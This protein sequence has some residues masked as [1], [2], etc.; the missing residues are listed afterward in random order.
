VKNE[1]KGRSLAHE[2]C[3]VLTLGAGHWIDKSK[4]RKA[5]SDWHDPNDPNNLMYPHDTYKKGEK[6]IES[7]KKLTDDQIKEIQRGA[8]RLGKT[9]V[10]KR[11]INERGIPVIHQMVSL[12]TVHGGFVD[13]MGDVGPAY[14]DLGAGFLYAETPSAELQMSLLLEGMFPEVVDGFVI[15]SVYFDTDNDATTGDAFY[16]AVGVDK[17][18]DVEVGVH[19]LID[20]LPWDFRPGMSFPA[21]LF[22]VATLEIT[23]LPSATIER[24]AK[25][26]D[27]PEESG[28]PQVTDYVDGVLLRALTKVLELES[29]VVPVWVVSED[30][31]GFTPGDTDE[32]GCEWD[33]LGRHDPNLGRCPD[34]ISGR[35]HYAIPHDELEV[36]GW[37]FTPLSKVEILVDDELIGTTLVEL[38]GTFEESFPW[39]VWHPCLELDPRG[40]H[41]ITAR[42]ES[43]LFDFFVVEVYPNPADFNGDSIVDSKDLASFADNWLS[44]CVDIP[45]AE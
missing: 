17:I 11:K 13:D 41:F 43:G 45:G 39:S 1:T 22:D 27:G 36:S 10:A 30:W 24:I 4:N 5:D 9:K 25:I 29:E 12:P 2:A 23:P 7:G 15:F 40:Y 38:D 42:E 26:V 32:A 37:D 16:S 31:P 6:V 44:I 35:P 14:I 8:K 33:R 28:L 34:C 21:Y 18:I 20:M 19:S 3:H